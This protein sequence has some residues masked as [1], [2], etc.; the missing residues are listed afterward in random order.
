M[1]TVSNHLS[2]AVQWLN[3]LAQCSCT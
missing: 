2:A 1:L 3:R